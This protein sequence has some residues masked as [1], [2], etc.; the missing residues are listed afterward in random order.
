M[1]GPYCCQSRSLS[2][3]APWGRSESENTVSP[4]GFFMSAATLA[5]MV[6]GAM[7]IEQ[8]R[9]SPA[10]FRMADLIWIPSSAA[11]CES[12]LLPTS[13]TG[14]FVE[15][16]MIWCTGTTDPTASTMRLCMVT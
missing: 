15:L 16:D 13:R 2:H 3:V 14:H 6:L 12:R 4:S 9:E 7:P 1:R 8:V 11:F 10:R 5:S